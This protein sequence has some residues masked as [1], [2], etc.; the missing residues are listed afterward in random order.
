MS[1]TEDEIKERKEEF[2]AAL[3]ERLTPNLR[4]IFAVFDFIMVGT[5]LVDLVFMMGYI[6]DTYL[7]LLVALNLVAVVVGYVS[8]ATKRR[9][10]RQVS[11][12][13]FGEQRDVPVESGDE[14]ASEVTEDNSEMPD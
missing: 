3:K 13:L 14:R 10:S 11:K 2:R 6:G 8:Y 5:I 7:Q 1:P 4:L 9:L 12:E